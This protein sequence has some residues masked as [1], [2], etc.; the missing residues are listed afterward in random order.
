MLRNLSGEASHGIRVVKSLISV[1]C[2]LTCTS[3]FI[4]EDHQLSSHSSQQSDGQ[5]VSQRSG[6]DA[7]DS[8]SQKTPPR[9]PGTGTVFRT[10]EIQHLDQIIMLFSQIAS[11]DNVLALAKDKEVTSNNVHQIIAKINWRHLV[12][13][14]ALAISFKDK[15]I[16]SKLAGLENGKAIVVSLDSMTKIMNLIKILDHKNGFSMMS[17]CF[18]SHG[19]DEILNLAS[20][21]SG[22]TGSSAVS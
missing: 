2:N 13:L 15:A 3:H 10:S 5:N 22:S 14:E 12:G 17:M 18:S 19:T 8:A 1:L 20:F 4:H 6:P 7:I 9:T 11:L 21:T 16:V